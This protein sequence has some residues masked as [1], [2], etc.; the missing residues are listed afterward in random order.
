MNY[1]GRIVYISAIMLAVL[2]QKTLVPVFIGSEYGINLVMMLVLAWT[3]YD[4]FAGYLTWAVFAG[5]LY[6]IFFYYPLGLH[7][8]F[9]ALVAYVLSFFANRFSVSLRSS[10]FFTISV[11]IVLLTI[12]LTAYDMSWAMGRLNAGASFIEEFSGAQSLLKNMVANGILFC[13]CYLSIKKLKWF[14]YYFT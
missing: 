3:I 7:A 12:A 14:I 6:D 4:G 1:K 9:F 2:L 5:C 11:L 8:I 13:A 10:G